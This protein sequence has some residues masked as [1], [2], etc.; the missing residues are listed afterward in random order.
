MLASKL[1]KPDKL[2]Y[3]ILVPQKLSSKVLI[4][5]IKAIYIFGNGHLIRKHIGQ[6]KVKKTIRNAIFI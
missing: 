2:S 5:H 3:N 1:D 4:E 6:R